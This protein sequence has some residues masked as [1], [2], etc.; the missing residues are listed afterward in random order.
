MDKLNMSEYLTTFEV[1]SRD[2]LHRYNVEH[3][4]ARWLRWQ[5]AQEYPDANWDIEIVHTN[6]DKDQIVLLVRC[7]IG[8][9]YDDASKKTSHLC[10]GKL[11]AS[12][13]VVT[14]GKKQC[15]LD[16]L[17]STEQAQSIRSRNVLSEEVKKKLSDLYS[18]KYDG[19][20]SRKALLNDIVVFLGISYYSELTV[21]GI[22]Y[23]IEHRFDKEKEDEKYKEY[24]AD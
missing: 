8:A 10:V 15:A 7:F 21:E 11:S 24:S 3:V 12:D 9:S 2:G 4:P 18:S 19:K 16:W 6:P 14:A 5:F 23:F 22:E 1:K 20:L 17:V 13:K